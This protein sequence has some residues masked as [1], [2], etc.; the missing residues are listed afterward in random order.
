MVV[1]IWLICALREL[2]LHVALLTLLVLAAFLFFFIFGW[3]HRISAHS[4]TSMINGVV[5]WEKGIIQPADWMR[6]AEESVAH[7]AVT[8][9]TCLASTRLLATN[10]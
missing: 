10:R 3:M 2:K 8:I 4:Q 5:F 6:F 7:A 9:M 1:T